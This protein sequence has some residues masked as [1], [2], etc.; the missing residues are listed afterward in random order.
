MRDLLREMIEA[1][2][3]EERP[4]PR[5]RRPVFDLTDMAYQAI[6]PF[7]SFAFERGIQYETEIQEEAVCWGDAARVR[8]VLTIM[9]D[10]AFKYVDEGGTIRVRVGMEGRRAVLE[11]GNSGP[12]I[13][14]EDLPHIFERFYR[15]DK[16]RR[17]D[18]SYGLGLAIAK[19][20]VR[21]QRGKLTVESQPGVWTCFRLVI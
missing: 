16:G 18:G 19:N 20:I 6:L 4:A 5:K 11:V 3:V 12:G 9:L 1:A 13:R 8:Q 10:N 14:A 21:E 2:R 7:D 15:C 17:A